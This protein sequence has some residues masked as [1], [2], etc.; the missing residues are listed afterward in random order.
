MGG[1]AARRAT[2]NG[3]PAAGVA[4]ISG[5]DAWLQHAACRGMDVNLFFVVRSGMKPAPEAVV[6]CASCRVRNECLADEFRLVGAHLDLYGYRA[7]MLS[8]S[9]FDELERWRHPCEGCR[10]ETTGPNPWC[11][12]ACEAAMMACDI[13]DG[14]QIAAMSADGTR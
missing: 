11:S 10:Q 7:G 1:P 8:A 4:A 12:D 2:S 3:S 14:P 13:S 5:E 6:A 9:R